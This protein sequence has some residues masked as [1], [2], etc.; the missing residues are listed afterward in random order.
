MVFSTIAISV[1]AYLG[2]P[3]AAMAG[4]N[5]IVIIGLLIVIANFFQPHLQ[6]NRELKML[7]AGFLILSL[8]IEFFFTQMELWKPSILRMIF[9]VS[10][11]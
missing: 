6:L 7:R 3:Y 11:V 4:N 5:I 8:M 9:L 2:N 10:T 1:S